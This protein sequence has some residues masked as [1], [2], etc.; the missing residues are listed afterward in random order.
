MQNIKW[1][2]HWTWRVMY[3]K[4]ATLH[5]TV[6]LYPM[7]YYMLCIIIFFVQFSRQRYIVTFVS[8]YCSCSGMWWN[9]DNERI[10]N[11]C[12]MEKPLPT[13][14]I[15]MVTVTCLQISTFLSASLTSTTFCLVLFQQ[16]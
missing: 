14:Q 4:L 5:K 9:N 8:G 6:I 1:T 2:V 11:N 7:Y 10:V 16:L 12:A 15:A 13:I 3:W